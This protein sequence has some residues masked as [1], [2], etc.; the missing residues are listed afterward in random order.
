MF[1]PGCFRRSARAPHAHQSSA[2]HHGIHPAKPSLRS[3]MLK[4]GLRWFVLLK[5][6]FFGLLP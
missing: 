4:P 5:T 6:L 2:Y 3:Q 1:Q